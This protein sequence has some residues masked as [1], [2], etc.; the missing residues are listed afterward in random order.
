MGLG[1]GFF[2]TPEFAGGNLT[3]QGKWM[4]SPQQ[5]SPR[6]Y[7]TVGQKVIKGIA[8]P[9]TQTCPQNALP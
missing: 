5:I 7:A 3:V 1:P 8:Q 9:K 6:A 4:W 2:W